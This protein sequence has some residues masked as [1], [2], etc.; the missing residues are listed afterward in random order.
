VPSASGFAYGGASTVGLRVTLRRRRR[1]ATS[2]DTPTPQA[3]PYASHPARRE[4]P[5]PPPQPP[6]S[7]TAPQPRRGTTRGHTPHTATRPGTR[8]LTAA[9]Q[10]PAKTGEGESMSS[11]IR[12]KAQA[13]RSATRSPAVD[14]PPYAKPDADDTQ[15]ILAC[16]PGYKP[17]VLQV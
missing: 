10:R 1:A 15:Y 7:P 13:R 16:T 6:S 9:S 8:T 2:G 12:L 17:Y 14:A 5:K 3:P 11:D 4:P